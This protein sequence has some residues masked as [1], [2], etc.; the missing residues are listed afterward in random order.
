[1]EGKLEINRLERPELVYELAVRGFSEDT[2]V[3]KMRTKLRACLKLEKSS[4]IK[5]PKHP[6]TF[7]DDCGALTDKFSELEA[8]VADFSD[9]ETSG[10]Y[11]KITSKLVHAFGRADRSVATTEAEQTQRTSFLVDFLGLQ[12]ELKSKVRRHRRSLEQ[13]TSG[14]LDLS[15]LAIDDGSENTD[16]EMS[17][18][19]EIVGIPAA[20]NSSFRLPMEAGHLKC[21]P[22]SKW[23]IRKFSGDSSKVS[24]NAFLED[25]EEL[26][27]SRNVTKEQL[28]H[29]A[30][31]LF[32]GKAL[33]W[34]RSIRSKVSSWSQLV[35]E[36]RLQFQPSNY[37]DR[38]FEEIKHRTQGS[39]ENIGMYIAVMSNMFN[40]LTV[41]VGE[42]TRLA[43]LM[44]NISPFYQSQLGLVSI[45]SVD[46]L[47]ELGRKLE[48]RKETIETFTPPPRNRVGLMEPDLAY[49]Y[50]DSDSIAGPSTTCASSIDLVCWN[51]QK[52]G[53]KANNCGAPRKKHC[54]RCGRPDY[55]VRS[56]PKCS[57]PPPNEVKR[58]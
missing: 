25:I 45:E 54:Y 19:E 36:L 57:R 14:P 32:I 10:A 15:V 3:A 8:L 47:L 4:E 13:G 58:Q 28:L 51:C 24:L 41:P 43:I 39:S 20:A 38:L 50:A 53:H 29:S 42:K 56:C 9:C 31:D 37:N 30:A 48:A 2:T 34:Y 11:L 33:I 17:S 7:Q 22:V 5:Y 26:R 1:M 52:P 21:V 35:C 55:T 44:K 12:S 40:R 46:Q 49:I 18:D 23:N 27:I 6:F 16:S